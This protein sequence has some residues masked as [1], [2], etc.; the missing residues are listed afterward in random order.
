[1]AALACAGLTDRGR[2]RETNQDRWF[3]DPEQ[4]LF[5]V[6]DGMGGHAA[7]GLAATAVVE[8]LPR[9][10]AQGLGDSPDLSA[11]AVLERLLASIRTL[12][13]QLR[14]KT[15]G[16]PGLDGMGSTLALALLLGRRALVAHLGD[17]RVYR[18]H[19][20]VLQRVTRDHSV[21]QML[22]EMGEI[23][24]DDV[25]NHPARGQITRYVG[26]QDEALPEARSLQLTGGDL[27]LLCSDGL[28]GMLPEP[29]ITAILA[30][31]RS[32][33]DTCRS[34]IEAANAAGGTDNI[35]ALLVA[36]AGTPPRRR[37]TS[38]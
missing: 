34:L 3:A 38:G 21:V 9:L 27:L 19:A 35:T 28:T 37:R 4:G 18:F 22:L 5:I 17:S 16:R 10:L 23:G 11:P 2:V 25:A 8:T 26:M 33:S 13:E 30:E 36:M 6:A 14:R 29:A 32:L 20:G 12:S 31:G 1:M 7:G 24:P 15:E